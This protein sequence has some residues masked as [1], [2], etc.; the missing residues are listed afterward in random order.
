MIRG[1]AKMFR[2]KLPCRCDDLEWV[3]VVFGQSN[4][5]GPAANRPLPIIKTLGCREVSQ[6]PTHFCVKLSSEETLRFSDRLKASAQFFGR[7]TDGQTITG[8]K[9]L[10]NVHSII[11]DSIF[12][13]EMI[14]SPHAPDYEWIYLDGSAIIEE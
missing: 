10:F 12:D 14:I 5:S 1:E 11:D 6:N 4:N 9:W 8:Q 7:T 2:F 3:N 13:G